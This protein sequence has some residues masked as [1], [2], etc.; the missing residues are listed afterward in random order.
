MGEAGVDRGSEHHSYVI[1][2]R[3][4]LQDSFHFVFTDYDDSTLI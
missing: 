1:L 2:L 3:T 4:L